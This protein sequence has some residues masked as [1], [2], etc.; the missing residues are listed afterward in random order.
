[1][2]FIMKFRFVFSLL[3]STTILSPSFAM[4]EDEGNVPPVKPVAK[5]PLVLFK[6]LVQNRAKTP[7]AGDKRDEVL[8]ELLKKTKCIGEVETSQLDESGKLQI[9]VL[10]AE[11]DAV[12]IIDHLPPLNLP[13]A[14]EKEVIPSGTTAANETE[15]FIV[16]NE[17]M[18]H[19]FSYLD[20]SDLVKCRL[21]SYYFQCIAD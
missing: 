14:S 2:V 11:R 10:D 12:F 8:K 16:P 5:L 6:E 13:D 20:S 21:V 17:T 1:M 4:M 3:I 19:I 18:Y 15:A 9:E 7:H